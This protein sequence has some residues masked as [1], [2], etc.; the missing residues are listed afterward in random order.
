M[1]YLRLLEDLKH[2][3]ARTFMQSA[4]NVSNAD[5]VFL[6]QFVAWF[7]WCFGIRSGMCRPG[8][9]GR[10]SHSIN[11]VWMWRGTTQVD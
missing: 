2:F 8:Y 4:D 9:D 6:A 5:H 1:F 10:Q 11:D 3:D 7:I